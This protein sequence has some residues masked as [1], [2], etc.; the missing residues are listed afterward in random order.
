MTQL[1]PLHQIGRAE[2]HKALKTSLD[3]AFG[4]FSRGS[5]RWISLE[6]PGLI[7]SVRFKSHLGGRGN[8][9]ELLLSPKGLS[10]AQADLEALWSVLKVSVLRQDRLPLSEKAEALL[11]VCDRYALLPNV[12][13]QPSAG[14]GRA[15]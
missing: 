3:L 1:G 14:A 2:L 13:S 15:S 8:S 7:L 9:L 6:T 4:H 12:P 11:F 10:V 5:R